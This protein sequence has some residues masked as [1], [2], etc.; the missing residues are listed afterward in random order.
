MNKINLPDVNYNLKSATI[1]NRISTI[2]RML[3]SGWIAI[4]LA[5]ESSILGIVLILFL[6]VA[7][8]KL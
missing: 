7:D 8:F 3:D 2:P 5:P 1:K 6:I 4:M